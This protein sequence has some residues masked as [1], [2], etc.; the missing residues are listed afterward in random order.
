MFSN[1]MAVH[2][3]SVYGLQRSLW[4]LLKLGLLKFKFWKLGEI[5]LTI[6]PLESCKGFI[7]VFL[8]VGSCINRPSSLLAL[9]VVLSDLVQEEL[10]NRIELFCLIED[11]RREPNVPAQVNGHSGVKKG[12][13]PEDL[14]QD[15]DGAAP[16]PARRPPGPGVPQ[17][18][19]R[20]SPPRAVSAQSHFKVTEAAQGFPEPREPP[21][22]V[23]PAR[24]RGGV[25][26]FPRG[27]PA[28]RP[29][30]GAARSRSLAPGAAGVP[31]RERTVG[32]AGAVGGRTDGRWRQLCS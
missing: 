26:R 16:G 20:E 11:N 3:C 19:P 7:H 10:L 18:K 32:R 30:P 6:R 17:G 21:G 9:R 13:K 8:K 2:H 22:A 1:S 23:V 15:H 4:S 14:S 12:G 31:G 24:G 5:S 27:G 28:R 25:A 29:D